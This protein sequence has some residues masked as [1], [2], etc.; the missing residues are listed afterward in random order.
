MRTVFHIIA[1]LLSLGARA[2]NPKVE[3]ITPRIV[4]VQWSADGTLP[5][6]NTGVCVYDRSRVK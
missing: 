2:G 4:R 3:F 6:N 5:G 1:L